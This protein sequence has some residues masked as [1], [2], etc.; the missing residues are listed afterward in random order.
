MI[1]REPKHYRERAEE[2]SV[3]AS[4]MKDPLCKQQWI[5]QSW[6]YML[7]ARQ[8]EKERG[9][10]IVEHVSSEWLGKYP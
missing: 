6:H 9:L 7:L 5:G 8:S 1:Y 4:I 3:I 2:C 10:P